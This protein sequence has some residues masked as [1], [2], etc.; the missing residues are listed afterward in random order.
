M[1][2]STVAALGGLRKGKAYL[3]CRGSALGPS[4]S[5]VP[6]HAHTLCFVLQGYRFGAKLVRGA[7][8]AQE[9]QRAQ[10]GGYPSPL[11]GSKAE[12]DASYDRWAACPAPTGCRNATS[13]APNGAQPSRLV[14]CCYP[15]VSTAGTLAR[16]LHEPWLGV[17]V[18]EALKGP[19]SGHAHAFLW[20]LLAARLKRPARAP[21]LAAAA[22]RLQPW[23]PQ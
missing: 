14:L 12:A 21:A 18:Y 22:G 11:H 7:Y 16:P 2:C 13:S 19:C 3:H 5:L 10:E 9:Q 1:S 4:S 20:R 15:C 6:L 23:P 17:D 8:L